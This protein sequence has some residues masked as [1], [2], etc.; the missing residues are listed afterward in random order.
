MLVYRTNHVVAPSLRDHAA[1][2]Q[3][4]PTDDSRARWCSSPSGR[5]SNGR[6]NA[7]RSDRGNI[8]KFARPVSAS[9]FRNARPTSHAKRQATGTGSSKRRP[10]ALNSLKEVLN[11]SSSTPKGRL[12][13]SSRTSLAKLQYQSSLNWSSARTTPALAAA[14]RRDHDPRSVT[15]CEG[16]TVTNSNTPSCLAGRR[17]VATIHADHSSARSVR[18]GVSTARGSDLRGAA[19]SSRC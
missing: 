3:F 12:K 11:S 1:G 10:D 17:S 9:C 16:S 19:G 13:R 6:L 8:M 5:V 14:R 2:D 7:V 18:S 4:P 15:S